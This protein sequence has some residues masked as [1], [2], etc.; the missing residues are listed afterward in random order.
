MF[1]KFTDKESAENFLFYL[2]T[3]FARFCLAMYKNNSQLE[4]GEMS[5]IPWLDFSIKW[6]DDLLF[7]NFNLDESE[8]K[9][10]SKIIPNYYN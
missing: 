6:E 10:I 9:F 1:F 5:L 3:N 8:I 7:K 2:K 4:C